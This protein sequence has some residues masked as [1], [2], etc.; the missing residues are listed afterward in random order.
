[1][2]RRNAGLS[3]LEYV[4]GLAVLAIILV[5]TGLFI[6]SLPRQLDPVFQFRAVALAEA[7]AEQV[8]AVKYDAANK[9]QEQTRCG[10]DGADVCENQATIPT[11]AEINDFT[12]VDD[13]RLWCDEGNA[14]AGN[15]LAQQLGMSRTALYARYLVQTCVTI[16]TDDAGTTFKR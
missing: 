11:D 13:F 1:M 8:L 15:A 6:S 3:L 2:L 7:L 16:G 12:H 10:I 5:G 14:I 4:V 9:P